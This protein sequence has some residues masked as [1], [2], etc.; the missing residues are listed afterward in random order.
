M[1]VGDVQ[2]VDTHRMKFSLVEMG[3]VRWCHT[4]LRDGLKPH[5]GQWHAM[6]INGWRDI[7][8]ILTLIILSCVNVIHTSWLCAKPCLRKI[9][10][11]PTMLCSMLQ[12]LTRAHRGS[13]KSR[14]LPASSSSSVSTSPAP[15]SSPSMVADNWALLRSTGES[16]LE[17]GNQPN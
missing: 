8:V 5:L 1:V 7:W 11:G 6:R 2:E 4:D 13:S 17:E 3:R 9:Q 12:F 15:P 10:A 16:P 14:S